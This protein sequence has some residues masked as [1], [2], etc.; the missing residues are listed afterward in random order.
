MSM[1][2]F[3][4]AVGP[5]LFSASLRLFGSYRAVLL[6]CLA[7]TLLLFAAAFFAHNPQQKFASGE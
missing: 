7:T 5:I 2:V 6:I 1:L 4:S 3:G